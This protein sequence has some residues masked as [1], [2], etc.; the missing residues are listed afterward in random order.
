MLT[1]LNLRYEVLTPMFLGGAEGQA[2]LRVPSI[3]GALRHWYRAI[4]S[5]YAR[6]EFRLF[7]GSGAQEGQSTILLRIPAP[8]EFSEWKWPDRNALRRFQVGRGDAAKNG[9]AYLGY[10]LGLK[11]NENRT[12]IPPGTQ[13]DLQCVFRRFRQLSMR[14]RR[15]LLACLWLLGHL[16]SLG[17]RARRGFGSLELSDWSAEGSGQPELEEEMAELPLLVES[18]DGRTWL[19]QLDGAIRHLDKHLS[20]RQGVGRHPRLGPATQ[21]AL[22][23]PERTPPGTPDWAGPVQAAGLTLQEFRAAREPD[24][25]LLREHLLAINKRGGKMLS[26]QSSPRSPERT[27]FG[28]PLTF[29]FKGLAPPVE[30]TPDAMDQSG[31]PAQR[32]P[33]PL[34]IRTARIG[35]Q[36]CAVLT[37]LDGAVPG[38]RGVRYVDRYRGRQD[39]LP[40]P[41]GQ[42]LDVFMDKCAQRGLR[43]RW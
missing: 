28:L 10:S 8:P 4:E 27:A 25:S 24:R 1:R 20:L 37:R 39:P 22:L 13:F 9:V 21:V 38:D 33:S 6:T 31:R 26:Q 18:T 15:G 16:G 17:T 29:R 32:H 43:W 30:F 41:E 36:H 11:G 34:W 23:E 5:N 3:K 2:E 40:P 12:A 42:L 14:D 19:K 35:R 7:G